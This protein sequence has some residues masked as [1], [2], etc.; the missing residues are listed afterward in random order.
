MTERWG[1]TF[2]LDGVPLP[3][4]RELL[5]E[6]EALGYTDAW[7][8]EVDG[9]DAFTPLALAAEWTSALRLGTAI[10]NVYTRGPALLAQTAA[11]VAEVAP[12]RFC[13]G[14]GSSSPAIVENWNG[15]KLERP[16]ARVR[17]TVAFL[18]AVF[19]GER[20]ASAALGVRG[21]RLARRLSSP[22]PI[23]VAALQE[24]MLALAGSVADG[25]IINWLAPKDVPKVVAVARDAA[26]AAGRDPDALEVVCRI[27]VIPTTNDEIVRAIARRAIAGYMTTPVYSGFQRWLGR[28]EALRPSQ[29]AWQAG[30][31][32]AATDLVPN[33]VIEE[34]FVAGDRKACLDKIE[35]YCRSGVT[36]PV[37]NFLPT[38]L[39]PKELAERNIAAVRELARPA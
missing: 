37:L 14:I 16:L 39:D 7:T 32:Q 5:A 20:A 21:F 38:A 17:E 12:G 18:R 2:P 19:A 11:A 6:A 24:R 4:H 34:L 35:A 31:R 36:V 22:P 13:L 23:F 10:A 29:E 15:A 30:D 3:A 1:L 28:G 33:D 9:L 25:V 27:F 26:K 8:A